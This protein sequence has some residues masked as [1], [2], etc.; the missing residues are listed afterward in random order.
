MKK[1]TVRSIKIT[2][3]E[4]LAAS[5]EGWADARIEEHKKAP[6]GYTARN[7]GPAAG[8]L[9]AAQDLRAL[10]REIQTGG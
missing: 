8:Q 2:E 3:L 9:G 10:I 4:S 7:Q 1:R 5:W 6:D